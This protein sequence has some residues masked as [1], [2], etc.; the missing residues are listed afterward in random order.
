MK[1][2]GVI[3]PIVTPCSK[4]GE[5][6][7]EGVKSVC[8]Y[9]IENGCQ[10]IFVCG[11]TGR[12]PWFGRKDKVNICRAARSVLGSNNHLFAGCMA[13]GFQELLENARIMADSGATAAVITSPCYFNYNTDEIEYIFLKY[14]DVSPLPVMLYDIPIFA[15]A[16][17]DTGMITRLA[18]HN[19]I[20]GFKD[21][22]ADI[23]RFNELITALTNVDNFYLIQ[24]KEHLLAESLYAGASGLTVSL[25]HIDPKLFVTLY[26]DAIHR[27]IDRANHCQE[28]VTRI[29]KIFIEC[30]QQRPE[31]STLFHC[32]NFIMK[33]KKICENI[34]LE[35]EGQTP[36]WLIEKAKQTLSLLKN[37]STPET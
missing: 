27:N 25:V 30:F 22:S 11:S 9:M 15:G 23:N 37:N 32:L 31:I 24:G 20:I 29:M 18:K 34:L 36:T 17:L 14:A 6:D 10:G 7:L 16:K 21:S 12:G 35:H 1:K 3:S 13:M 2:I 4:K 33:E 19:N 5:P 28:Q 8:R 26:N